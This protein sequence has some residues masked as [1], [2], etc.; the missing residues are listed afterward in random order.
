MALFTGEIDG[1]KAVAN[2]IPE[3]MSVVANMGTQ[4]YTVTAGDSST[5][6]YTVKGAVL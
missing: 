4:N 5:L 2:M 3:Q 1:Y 6:Q